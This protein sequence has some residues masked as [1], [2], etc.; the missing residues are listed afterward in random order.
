M[1]KIFSENWI[2]LV[3][4]LF[5]MT[6]MLLAIRNN[7][8]IEK[9]HE[10]QQQTEL[11]RQG[12]QD[13][14]TQTMH[15]LDLGVRGFGLTKDKNMLRPYEEAIQKTPVIFRQLDSL[16]QKQGYDDKIVLEAVKRE[17]DSYIS[18]SK[19][20]I[21]FAEVD[22]MQEFN[23]MLRQDKGY[24]VWKKYAAFADP[25]FQ[26]EENLNKGARLN[27]KAAMR[28]NLLLQIS[29]MLLAMPM[30]Y[31]FIVKMRK[32]RDGRTALLKKVEENDQLYVFNSGE[33]H[34][35]SSVEIN[36]TSIQNVKQASQFIDR[37]AGG[38]YDVNWEGITDANRELNKETLAGNLLQLRDKL[39][40]LKQEDDKR[41]WIN[42]GLAAFAEITRTHQHDKNRLVEKCVIYLTR[43]L[44]AQQAGL[45]LL[46]EEQGEKYLS[47]AACYA[48]DRKKFVQKRINIGEGLIGQT[49]LEGELVRLKEIPE[50]YTHI[51]SGLGQATPRYLAIVPF[52]YDS[53]VPAI[54]ELSSFHDLEAHHLQFLQK[55]GEYLASALISSQTTMKMKTLLDEAALNE[56]HMRQREEELRQNMEELQATQEQLMRKDNVFQM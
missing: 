48:F 41:N 10:L 36:E 54:I 14:L 50:G 33:N 39:K 44:S 46:M 32:E 37:M 15:G 24:D 42:E 5:L 8:V 11:I 43:Y 45:F 9:N 12:T 31:M 13:I 20:M 18:F 27:Y 29:I 23:Q 35:G 3:I 53:L 25:L 2:I 55:A 16:L 26:H 1:K 49:F 40:A 30:L 21:L 28:N 4:G 7:Y 52:K 38:N 6:S 34:H 51:T 22:S 19:K 47:L 56:K 17:A